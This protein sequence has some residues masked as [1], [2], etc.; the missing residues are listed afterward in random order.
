MPIIECSVSVDAFLEAV[1]ELSEEKRVHHSTN[2]G[3]ADA[4]IGVGQP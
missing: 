3:R 2:S 1:N 4:R